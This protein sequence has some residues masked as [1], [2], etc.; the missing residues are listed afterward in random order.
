MGESEVS[1]AFLKSGKELFSQECK[2]VIGCAFLDQL[3]EH[4]RLEIAFAGRSN[5]GKST[6]I[7]SLTQQYN[8]ARTSST[9]GR[10]QQ[11][12]YF[13]LAERLYLVDLPGYGYAKAP[14]KQVQR[15]NEL[16]FSYLRGRPTLRRVFL[17]VD[18]RRGL[19]NKDE[20]VMAMLDKAAVVF[21]IIVTKSDKV[22][23]I[24]LPKIINSIE[25]IMKKHT[26]AYPNLI[27]TSSQKNIGIDV[28]RA[29]IAA[30]LQQ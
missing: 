12:N 27:I 10:T 15:W 7:N 2:F 14:E 28:V 5:V 20:D 3:P 29:E 1:E 19:T 22:N 13:D 21:Q 18:V 11:I 23:K 6:L 24:E 16:V 30:M 17:L 25:M 8:L 4:D 9:P 26:A